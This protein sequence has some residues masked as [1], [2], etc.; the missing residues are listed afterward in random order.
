MKDFTRIKNIIFDL[1]A[2]IIPIDFS[3]TFRA[4]ASLSNLPLEEIQSRYQ[5]S[6]LFVEFEKGII[7]N[8]QFLVGVRQLLELS[9]S[10]TDQ[11]LVDA[12]NALLLEIPAERVHRIQELSK[13]YRVFLLS[14]TNP[15]HIAEVQSI[16]YRN[17]QIAQLEAIFE[18][19]WYSYDLGLIKPGIAI[20]QKVLEQKQLA[21]AETIFL[22][23]SVDNVAGA[24]A[25]GIQALLVD[26]HTSLLE[27]LKHA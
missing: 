13:Q 19:A 27:L 1:G 22:D 6:T 17:T 15:I 7:G 2:V 5:A 16:L 21:A 8:F 9:D 4:F 11:Q 12:W 10:I 20:Y 24:V 14:N 26:E 25:A 18:K 23:D 3:L